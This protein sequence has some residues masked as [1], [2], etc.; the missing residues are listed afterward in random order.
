MG[1]PAGAC[2]GRPAVPEPLMLKRLLPFS[3][4]VL[5]LTGCPPSDDDDS[6]SDD[7]DAAAATEGTLAVSFRMDAD[8]ADSMDE[9]AVGSFWGSI[10]LADEVSGIGPDEGA[11]SLGDVFVEVVDMTGETLTSDVLFTSEPLPVGWI[12]ILGFVDSDGT[13]IEGDRSPDDGDPVTL[14]NDNLFEVFGGVETPAEIFFDF[15]NP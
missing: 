14:P 9:P 2:Y 10:Y 8:W 4:L 6:A 7:D 15:L 3:M 11:E 12:A 5:V 13:S 1:S